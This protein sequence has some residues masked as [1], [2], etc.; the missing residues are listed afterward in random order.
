MLIMAG[1]VSAHAGTITLDGEACTNSKIC[2]AIPNDAGA[3]V[4]LY[5]V[6]I[7]PYVYLYL[8]GDQYKGT[9]PGIYPYPASIDNLLMQDAS[10]NILYLTAMFSSYTTCSRY[11]TRHWTLVSG[12][13]RQ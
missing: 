6:V 13:I 2:Y 3:V 1:L 4:D 8:D 9:L 7:H 12:T 11:C 10:G 5:A